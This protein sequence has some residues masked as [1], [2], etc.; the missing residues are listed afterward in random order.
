MKDKPKAGWSIN[1]ATEFVQISCC[2]EL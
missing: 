2:N 1:E